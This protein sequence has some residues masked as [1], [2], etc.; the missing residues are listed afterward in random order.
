MDLSFMFLQPGS[1]K[2][3]TI[4]TFSHKLFFFYFCFFIGPTGNV[5]GINS[6]SPPSKLS[7][8]I[9]A[10]ILSII[11]APEPLVIMPHCYNKI[12]HF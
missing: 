11:Y 1:L 6:D 2:T 10:R 4:L 3:V 8:L 12:D 9:K 5:P 7:K